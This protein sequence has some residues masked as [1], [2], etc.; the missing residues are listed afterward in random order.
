MYP[1]VDPSVWC[2]NGH[3]HVPPSC[4]QGQTALHL[5]AYMYCGANAEDVTNLLI[6]K[7]ADV[8][9]KDDKVSDYVSIAC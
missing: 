1:C 8:N 7:G 3:L 9:A 6:L 2:A 4:F 5:A